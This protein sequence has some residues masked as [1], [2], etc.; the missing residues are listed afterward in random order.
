MAQVG[1][2]DPMDSQATLPKGEGMPTSAGCIHGSGG[3]DSVADGGANG[4]IPKV[5]RGAR[6]RP[7][8]ETEGDGKSSTWR[9]VL[10]FVYRTLG[11][12]GSGPTSTMEGQ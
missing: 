4:G 7:M 9:G 12:G 10:N 5:Y 8:A 11:R 6:D 1:M 3:A 2:R